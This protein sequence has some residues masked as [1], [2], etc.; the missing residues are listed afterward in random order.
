M[1][2]RVFDPAGPQRAQGSPRRERSLHGISPAILIDFR[3]VLREALQIDIFHSPVAIVDVGIPSRLLRR[4]A[5]LSQRRCLQRLPPATLKMPK[6]RNAGQGAESPGFRMRGGLRRTFVRSALA[7]SQ[8]LTGSISQSCSSNWARTSFSAR[9]ALGANDL[10]RA[11]HCSQTANKGLPEF[12]TCR[13][14]FGM[15]PIFH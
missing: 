4:K 13:V 15:S 1:W 7:H 3:P 8:L 5:I 2:N 14:R 10:N 12:T 9:S 11:L 6:Q